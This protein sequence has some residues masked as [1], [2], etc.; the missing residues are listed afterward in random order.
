MFIDKGILP[1]PCKITVEIMPDESH[2]YIVDFTDTFSLRYDVLEGRQDWGLGFWF[3]ETPGGS[4]LGRTL[5]T[6][7]QTDVII[8]VDN[9]TIVVQKNG[10]I[11]DILFDFSPELT[12]YFNVFNKESSLS[13]YILALGDIEP[14]DILCP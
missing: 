2:Y 11:V 1:E 12:Y 10:A 8:A 4:P 13:K 7:P 3:S 14:T 9:G 6:T 5:K